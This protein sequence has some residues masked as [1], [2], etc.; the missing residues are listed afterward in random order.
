M[1][2]MPATRARAPRSVAGASG[3]ARRA[4]RRTPCPAAGRPGGGRAAGAARTDDRQLARLE[5]LEQLLVA[6]GVDVAKEP[7]P[8]RALQ[9][10][11]PCHAE[12]M[13]GTCISNNMV[14]LRA[15]RPHAG[16]AHGTA[17]QRRACG[18]CSSAHG[19]L[20]LALPCGGMLGRACCCSH[21]AQAPRLPAFYD[22]PLSGAGSHMRPVRA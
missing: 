17:W 22:L 6:R 18:S 4:A 2:S 12:C 20:S 21:L 11:M 8:P 9:L 16:G 1:Q 14:R 15:Q 3:A 5:P 19:R 10:R 13:H 7:A